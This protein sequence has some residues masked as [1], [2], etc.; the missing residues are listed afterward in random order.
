MII[1]GSLLPSYTDT[2]LA[3]TLQSFNYDHAELKSGN[4]CRP[5][6]MVKSTCTLMLF[7]MNAFMFYTWPLSILVRQVTCWANL[8]TF[9]QLAIS[10]YCSVMLDS[11][12]IGK[13]RKTLATHH[14]LFEVIVPINLMVTAVYWI[15]LSDEVLLNMHSAEQLSLYLNSIL[16]HSIPMIAT[17]A[18][19]CVTDI[20]FKPSH[21]IF[22]VPM[23]V[24]YSCLNYYATVT[25]GKPVYWFL[26]WKDHKTVLIIAGL[27]VAVITSFLFMSWLTKVLRQFRP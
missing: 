11:S 14:A 2:E 12:T 21:C 26:D 20:E 22:Y 25:S 15:L 27:L 18:N 6:V 4:K 17:L 19:F 23:C 3:Q 13:A 7:L 9:T 8:L 1:L 16:V 10:L 5:F 24:L